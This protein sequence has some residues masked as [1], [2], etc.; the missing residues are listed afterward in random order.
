[1]KLSRDTR[2]SISSDVLFQEVS[3]E[4]VLLDLASENYFGLNEIGTRIWTLLNEKKDVGEI[5]CAL[6]SEYE[7]KQVELE[8]DVDDLLTSLLEGGLITV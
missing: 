3:G 5:I 7:V 6:M 2:F 4:S 8:K 1:M